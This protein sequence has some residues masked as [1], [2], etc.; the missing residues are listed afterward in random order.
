MP[1][2]TSHRQFEG[3]ARLIQDNIDETGLRYSRGVV[4]RSDILTKDYGDENVGWEVVHP[5]ANTPEERHEKRIGRR[6]VQIVVTPDGDQYN[7]EVHH[8]NTSRPDNE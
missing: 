1:E 4:S 3:P 2:Q 6:V 8:P 7:I 5:E